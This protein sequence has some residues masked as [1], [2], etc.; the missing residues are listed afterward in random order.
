MEEKE[1][2]NSGISRL[3]PSNDDFLFLGVTMSESKGF[4]PKGSDPIYILHIEDNETVQKA[5]QRLLRKRFGAEVIPAKSGKEAL[6]I[7]GTKNWSVIMS[8]WTIEEE[9]TGGDVFEAIT[10]AHPELLDRYVFMSSDEKA[11]TLCAR[12]GLPFLPK[13]AQMEQIYS[14]IEQVIEPQ[15]AA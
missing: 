12:F 7:L 11:E 2:Q 3:N 8:D 6:D 4:V 10:T 5:V 15:V 9:L 1:P 13:P 14:V